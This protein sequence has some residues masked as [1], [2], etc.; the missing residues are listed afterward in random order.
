M[1]LLFEPMY[2]AVRAARAALGGGGVRTVLLSPQGRR[3]EQAAVRR[4]AASRPLVLICGRYEGVD[5]RLVETAVDEELS[6]GDFV[7]SGGEPAALALI[8]AMVR[9]LPGALGHRDSAAEDSFANGL[10][11]WPHYTRPERLD[12]EYGGRAVPPVLLGGDH[13]AV[14]RWREKQALG[15]TWLRRPDLLHGLDTGRRGLL[16]EFIAEQRPGADAGAG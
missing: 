13:G 15:R 3:L 5:E 16:E 2:R 12:S 6:L 4:L 8:D 9:L 7:L 11:D 10:L 14:R 1:V